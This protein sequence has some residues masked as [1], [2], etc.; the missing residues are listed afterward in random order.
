MHVYMAMDPETR[1]VLVQTREIGEFDFPPGPRG[2]GWP[3][4]EGEL[5]DDIMAAALS[6]TLSGPE[7]DKVHREAWNRAG[8]PDDPDW[9]EL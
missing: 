3:Q 8:G 9:P 5:D 6:G 7:L 1:R 4:R 2:V